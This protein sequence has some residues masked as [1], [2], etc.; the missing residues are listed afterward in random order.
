MVRKERLEL[1]RVPPLEP[2]SSASTN[3]ATFAHSPLPGL[4][5]LQDRQA[6][7]RLWKIQYNPT[8]IGAKK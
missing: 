6:I 4:K 1:S 7:I 2:K 3:S 8:K 5:V